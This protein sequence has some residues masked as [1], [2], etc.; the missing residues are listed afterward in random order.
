MKLC[1]ATRAVLYYISDRDWRV[2]GCRLLVRSGLRGAGR[3]ALTRHDGLPAAACG[4]GAPH[5]LPCRD[6]CLLRAI[7][8]WKS[9][10]APAARPLDVLCVWCWSRW[11]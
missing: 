10:Y 3:A 4:C 5:T 7:V 9:Y 11:W 8:I 6:R 2:T 1:K